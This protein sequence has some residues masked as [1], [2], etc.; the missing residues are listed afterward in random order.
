ML[1]VIITFFTIIGG[2]FA[3]RYYS[4]IF[5]MKKIK[6][7]VQDIQQDLTQNQMLHM[8]V[9]EKH[10]KELLCSLNS[11]LD[12]MQKE[13][14]R[15]ETQEREF[16]QQIE[17]I[18]HDLRTPLTVILGYIKLYKKE[19]A[20]QIA[21]D[22]DLAEMITTL[23]SKSE[24]MKN[25]V[26]QFYDYSRIHAGDYALRL[27][28]IDIAKMLRESLMGNYQVLEHADLNV[29]VAIPEHPVWVLGSES[30]LE[31]IFVNLLQ[32]VSRYAESF[33]QIAIYEDK[34]FVELSFVNDTSL[35]SEDDLPHLFE[36]FYMQ[37]SSRNQNGT[38]L[39]LT[40]AKSLA[41]EM[42]GE[43]SVE[44]IDCTDTQKSSGIVICFRLKVK[45][46]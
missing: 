10:M 19:H 13:R 6:N 44:K 45:R 43:L 17:T 25:L 34:D 1:Y 37:D 9:P 39:G 22:S 28:S 4:L 42:N 24:T 12:E 33:F 11:L 8:P 7:E 18:S 35:L 21:L 31:R 5:A 29:D 20:K 15:Y 23:E 27:D 32:N 38:G 40:V 3:F 26:T 36:R 16:Q 46:T 2:Y 14:K 41:E 30:A